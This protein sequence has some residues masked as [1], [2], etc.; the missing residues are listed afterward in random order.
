MLSDRNMLIFT[1]KIPQNL[2]TA[3]SVL[4]RVIA[5][6]RWTPTSACIKNVESQVGVMK[7]MTEHVREILG[8]VIPWNATFHRL[9]EMLK[10]P[11]AHE[12]SQQSGAVVKEMHDQ[13][14]LFYER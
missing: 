11:E 9:L 6:R 13:L 14:T 10:S 3:C 7:G 12:N 1:S 5:R 8:I 2:F 4:A